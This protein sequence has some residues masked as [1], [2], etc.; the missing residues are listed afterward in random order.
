MEMYLKEN[1]LMIKNMKE[2]DLFIM[3]LDIFM[4]E[5]LKKEEKTEKEQ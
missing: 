3:I 1:G 2:V 4:K 5:K